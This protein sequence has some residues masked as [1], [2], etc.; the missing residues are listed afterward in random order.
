MTLIYQRLRAPK[1][2]GH[3][4]QVPP[5]SDW[6]ATLLDNEVL[7]SGHS[8]TLSGT[9]I[10]EVRRQARQ[11]LLQS[12]LSYTSRYREIFDGDLRASIVMAGHQPTLFHP[13]VWYKN[14]VLSRFAETIDAWAINLVVDNDYNP[15]RSIR[16]P[17]GTLEQPK[18]EWL[19]YDSHVAC[20][21]FETESL[22]SREVFNKFGQSVAKTISAFVDQPLVD[23]LW[24][25]AKSGLDL[26]GKPSLAIAAGRHRLEQDCGLRTLEVPVSQVCQTPSFACFAAELIERA[27]ALKAIYNEQLLA[28]RRVNKIRSQSHPVPELKE[29]D[30]WVEV[31]F[32]VWRSESPI[33]KPLYVELGKERISLTDFDDIRLTLDRQS[34]LAAQINEWEKQ[35][36]SLRTRALTTTMYARLVL[37]DMFVHGIGGG[38]YDQ[39]TDEII[40]E[41]FGA[42]PP[43]FSVVTATHQL[44]INQTKFT[45]TDVARLKNRLRDL[46]FHAEQFGDFSDEKF[47]V[48]AEKKI[49]HWQRIPKEGS[50]KAWH[51]EMESINEA[52]RNNLTTEMAT[53]EDEIHTMRQA[54]QRSSLLSSREFSFCL[55]DEGIIER[56]RT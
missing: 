38:K 24:P 23:R 13:G 54:V 31:P 48:F 12:A 37:C 27:P 46:N 28:Y 17:A 44:P 34:D 39:L 16:V 47:R 53:L 55:F 26:L 9:P 11:R 3:S 35:G 30:D 51:D 42:E 4:L 1:N 43:T 18:M 14:F 2:N 56:L 19:K 8:F 45:Q 21:P 50:K 6:T 52:L 22:H 32:W 49:Q 7:F 15:S 33:R 36:V 25:F 40:R 5:L 10:D 20:G 29:F 41:F